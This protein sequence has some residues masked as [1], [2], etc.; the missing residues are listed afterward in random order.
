[1]TSR[2]KA[3]RL[4]DLINDRIAD[5]PKPGSE[6]DIFGFGVEPRSDE[7]VMDDVMH[8]ISKFAELNLDAWKK[9][10]VGSGYVDQLITE[11]KENEGVD[12]L[13]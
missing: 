5:D 12:N 10:R 3:K 7:Q 11:V 6:G 2:E 13:P 4:I 9:T 8:E 1:M